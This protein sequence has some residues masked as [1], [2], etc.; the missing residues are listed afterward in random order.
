M[1][2]DIGCCDHILPI[3]DQDAI[4]NFVSAESKAVVTVA[5]NCSEIDRTRLIPELWRD[6]DDNKDGN[7]EFLLSDDEKLSILKN[8]LE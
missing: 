6:K 3:E 1:P 2:Q 5:T 4:C 8:L 7:D